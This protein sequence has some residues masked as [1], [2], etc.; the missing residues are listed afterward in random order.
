MALSG[1]KVT[2]SKFLDVVG[3]AI[4][5]IKI[6]SSVTADEPG[7]VS[8]PFTTK[9]NTDK[10]EISFVK[11]TGRPL[12]VVLGDGELDFLQLKFKRSN[13]IIGKYLIFTMIKNN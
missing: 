1:G 9:E 8:F 13:K 3:F 2:F 11:T 4:V 10:S 5:S 6:P 7:S 12:V